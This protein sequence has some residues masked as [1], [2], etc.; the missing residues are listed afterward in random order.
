MRM[1]TPRL[2]RVSPSW[3]VSVVALVV[4]TSTGAYAA[5]LAADSVG[6][7]QLKDDAVTSAKVRNG[8]LKNTDFADGTLLEGP[9]GPQGPQGPAGPLG[10]TGPQGPLGPAGTAR[11]SI[12]VNSS[13]TTHS[14]KGAL[15]GASV[16][17]PETGVYCL[18]D[19]DITASYNPWVVT[20][21]FNHYFATVNDFTNTS[22]PCGTNDAILI[23]IFYGSTDNPSDTQFMLA[24]L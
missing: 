3:A 15:V 16:T 11:G 7:R 6:T 20:F 2:P 24:L 9:T 17:N 23:E 1:P 22:D 12:F 5:G 21:G 4:A 14:A 10:P 8:T 13:G 18:T 19:S